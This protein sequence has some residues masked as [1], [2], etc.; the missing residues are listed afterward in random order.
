MDYERDLAN[1]LSNYIET[2][3]FSY[4]IDVEQD[5]PTK[6]IVTKKQA[7]ILASSAAN[8]D[9]NILYD[10]LEWL[11]NSTYNPQRRLRTATGTVVDCGSTDLLTSRLEDF[12]VLLNQECEMVTIS[13]S[14]FAR[15]GKLKPNKLLILKEDHN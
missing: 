13:G 7:V 15:W 5:L 2:G 12:E 4:N 10:T 14:K 1:L 8:S 9:D 6:I 3:V 11:V